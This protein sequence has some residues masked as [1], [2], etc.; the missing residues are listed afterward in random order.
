MIAGS[1]FGVLGH[2]WYTFL[3]KRF[4]GQAI[5]TVLKKLLLEMA[6]GPPFMCGFFLGI[7][8]LEGKSAKD[9]IEEFKK[10]FLII[11]IVRSLYFLNFIFLYSI[12]YLL[13]LFI[14]F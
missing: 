9:S 12:I 2:V 14:Y 11:L 5:K 10:N 8:Y 7:G 3:D 4:P 6:I 1:A 13:I